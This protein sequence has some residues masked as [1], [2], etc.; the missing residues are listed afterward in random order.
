MFRDSR[1]NY[2]SKAV[3]GLTR[4]L[5]C[6]LNKHPNGESLRLTFP[7]FYVTIFKVRKDKE[8]LWQFDSLQVLCV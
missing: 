2:S 6:Y 5:S 7:V 1:A 3:W 4:V 8:S